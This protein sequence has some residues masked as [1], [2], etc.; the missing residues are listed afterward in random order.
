MWEFVLVPSPDCELI[1]RRVP[2]FDYPAVYS[3]FAGEFQ[4]ALEDVGR[5]G[6]YIQQADMD[7]FERE[8]AEYTGVAHCVCVSNATDGL[9]LACMAGNLPVGGEVIISTHTMVATASS[10]HFAGGVPVPVDVGLDHL[11]DPDAVEAAITERTVA[12]CPTQLNG[13]TCDMDALSEIAERHGLDLYEDSAQGLGSKFKGRAAGSFGRGNCLS[14]YP[15]KILGTL[16][17][18][19]A[20]L[21]DSDEMDASL[22]LLRDH[23]RID[24]SDTALWGFNSRMDN[25]AAAF[26]R[27][28]FRHFDETV[29]RRRSIA[30]RYW[31]L[32]GDVPGV[33]LPPSPVEEGEHFDTFQNFEIECDFRDVLQQG[34][35]VRGVGTL[36][37]WGGWP[38]HR[39]DKLGFTNSLP[40]ADALFDRML[41]LPMNMALTDEDVDYV[42]DSVLEIAEGVA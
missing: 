11:I 36:Q 25:L 4:A 28:Q 33:V 21:T 15:A 19:G 13:R 6:A 39:F 18:G 2:F 20:V 17:D 41:M 31:D 24:R 1:L 5:R 10:I 22:R 32:L 26:L 14:F 30:S 38:I 40:E 35:S 34:L 27:I 37:Q 23:G 29:A 3:R 42:C 8:V 16:G 12:I 7:D 9:Q